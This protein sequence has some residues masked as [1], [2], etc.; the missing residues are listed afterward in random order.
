MMAFFD[1]NRVVKLLLCHI[2]PAKMD[3][4]T[5]NTIS[6]LKTIKR[7]LRAYALPHGVREAGH[8]RSAFYPQERYISASTVYISN[9]EV[10]ICRRTI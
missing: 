10:A 3:N 6:N 9:V 5:E 7:R 4:F 8:S 1:E 2:V